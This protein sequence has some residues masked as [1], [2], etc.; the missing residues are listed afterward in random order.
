[1]I[2]KGPHSAVY[3][4]RDEKKYVLRAGLHATRFIAKIYR[5]YSNKRP[6]SN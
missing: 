4:R 6:T 5:I 3:L 2:K 1:M